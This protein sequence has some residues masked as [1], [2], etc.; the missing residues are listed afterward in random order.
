LELTQPKPGME[1]PRNPGRQ[2]VVMGLF[3]LTMISGEFGLQRIYPEYDWLGDFGYPRTYL[4]LLLIIIVLGNEYTR[5]ADEPRSPSMVKWFSWVVALHIYLAASVCWAPPPERGS[6][7]RVLSVVALSLLLWVALRIFRDVPEEK[8]KLAF[9]LLFFIAIAYAAAGLMGTNENGRMA[10]AYGGP[11]VFVRV[12]VTGIFASAYL[13][14]KNRRLAW[15]A[16]IPVFFACA[17]ASGS[18][19]GLL[20]LLLSVPLFVLAFG[21]RQYFKVA[22]VLCVVA[23]L[24]VVRY[25][26]M[27]DTRFGDWMTPFTRYVQIGG[28]PLDAE[29]DFG[30]RG[31]LWTTAHD[32]FLAHPIFGDGMVDTATS[33]QIDAHP[34]NLVLATARDGG[35]VGLFL[36]LV[37]SVFLCRRWFSEKT[38]EHKMCFALGSF[39]FFESMFSGTYYDARFMWLFLLLYL[40]PATR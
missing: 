34:H 15:L 8:I 7:A 4:T 6:L 1:V 28:S 23:L 22:G 5:A 20:S 33:S 37:P 39:Y 12:M 29:I 13:T 27:A 3:L 17:V 11:N 19:G 30:L 36:L 35:L 21:N 14:A 25:D 9:E 38:I 31:I 18:R 16:P 2:R 32:T 40:M 10:M 26:L 24:I